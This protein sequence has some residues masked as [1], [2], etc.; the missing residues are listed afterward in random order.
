MKSSISIVV[1]MAIL[2][3]ILNSGVV[4]YSSL[5]FGL[6]I[7]FTIIVVL[8]AY[9]SNKE[10][11]SWKWAIIHPSI[12]LIIKD[13]K[14]KKLPVMGILSAV[15][16]IGSITYSATAGTTKALETVACSTVTNIIKDKDSVN[17]MG[18]CVAV[19]FTDKPASGLYSGKAY[20]SSGMT[21]NVTSQ[22]K[23][24]GMLYT[25]ISL[26]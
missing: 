13:V 2:A 26:F 24:D 22:H 4:A 5:W 6:N 10:D 19:K 20:L 21:L 1:L 17:E 23:A 18:E 11:G 7:V 14:M 9:R 3:I 15:I 16:I 12:Y 8:I 25:R